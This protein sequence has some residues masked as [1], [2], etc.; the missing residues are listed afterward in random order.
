MNLVEIT[1]VVT[2]FATATSRAIRA[3]YDWVEIHAAHGYLLHNF[4]SPISNH[5]T[6]TYG[7]SLENRSRIVRE[8]ARRCRKELGD[9]KVLAVRLSH[10]DWQDGGW[11]TEETVQLSRWLKQD[12][13]DLIDVSSG[14]STPM[15]KIPLGPAYQLPGAIAVKTGADIPVAAVGLIT[16]PKQADDIIRS[17]QADMIYLA[18]GMLR[19]P[20]WPLEAAIE[21]G[22]LAALEV[23]HS[24]ILHTAPSPSLATSRRRG[25]IQFSRIPRSPSLKQKS[26]RM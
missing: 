6:D 4:L 25:L 7:G 24:T 10:T 15:P 26:N 2:A 5:R 22:Q 16:G 21:L 12:G 13:V 11:T 18:R 1:G 20:Y 17:N 14:G 8:V 3:G 9:D 23:P 19:S